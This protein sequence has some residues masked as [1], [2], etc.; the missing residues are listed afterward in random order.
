MDI[1]GPGPTR[2]E[3]ALCIIEPTAQLVKGPLSDAGGRGSNPRL[4]GLRV[5]PFQASG[6]IGTLQSRA[7]GLQSIMQGNSIPTT[8]IFP[9]VKQPTKTT[10]HDPCRCP[11]H[12]NPNRVAK[13]QARSQEKAAHKNNITVHVG[14]PLGIIR[15]HWSDAEKISM[16]PAQGLYAQIEKCK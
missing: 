5:S 2:K 6:G 7:S 15:E 14:F 12:W 10:M 9:R 3:R 13:R 11:A 16:A 8:N 4:G 1:W